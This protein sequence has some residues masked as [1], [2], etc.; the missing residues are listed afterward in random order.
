MNDWR[1]KLDAY[2]RRAIAGGPGGL[3]VTVRMAGGDSSELHQAGL[4]VHTSIGDVVAGHVADLATLERIASLPSV[5]EIHA[6]QPLYDE[7]A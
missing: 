3:D 6:T 1:Q 7:S 2:S 4:E 5:A